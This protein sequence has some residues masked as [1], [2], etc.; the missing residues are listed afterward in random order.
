[1]L[2]VPRFVARVPLP[3]GAE[4]VPTPLLGPLLRGLLL[5]GL[6]RVGGADRRAGLPAPALGGDGAV[7]RACGCCT[8]RSSTSAR[9]GTRFG[10]ESLLLE[11]GFL[12]VFLGNDDVAPPILVLF[13]L[14]WILFRVEFG[15]GLIKMRGDACWRK[16]TC[17]DY[18]HETQPMPGPLSWFFHHLPRPLH[19]VEVAANHVTQLARPRPAVHPAAGRHGRRVPDDRH[20]AV[21]G[22]VGQ[23]RLAELDHHRARRRRRSGSRPT[24]RPCP[25][26]PSGTRSWSSPSPR[27]SSPS[28]PAG[29]QH[30]LPPPADEPLL[31]PAAPGQHLRRVRQRQPVRGTRWCRGHGRRRTARGLGVAGVRVQGQAGRSSGAGRASSRR[32]TCAWTG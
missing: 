24:R 29:P 5:D 31:R 23:L 32:T 20:P 19:R 30:A 26:R 3:A 25:A 8:C 1:M 21:A 18:H 13:L 9:P 2:P 16:L 11:V 6:R 28:V 4:P 10:W 7:A 22:A 15:A 14:R 17:L 27:C 12:A